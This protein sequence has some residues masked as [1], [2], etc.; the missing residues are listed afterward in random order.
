MAVKISVFKVLVFEELVS[1]KEKM[2]L[3][4]SYKNKA[5]TEK[6]NAEV[7]TPFSLHQRIKKHGIGSPRLVITETSE[8]IAQL[9]Q[10][11]NNR[12][13]C[14]IELRPNGIIIGFRSLLESYGLVIPYYKLVI[15][16]GKAEEYSLYRDVQC[17]KIQA[18]AKDKATHRFMAKVMTEKNNAATSRIEDM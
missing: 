14:N 7:G 15:Y 11:D 5:I 16:K 6:I 1:L 17:I 3:N 18:K 9:L 8:D 2:L 4:V 10:L 13:V 12:D